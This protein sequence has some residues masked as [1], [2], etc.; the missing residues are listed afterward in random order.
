MSPA[1]FE[2][3]SKAGLAGGGLTGAELAGLVELAGPELAGHS[4]FIFSL[5]SIALNVTKNSQLF[6]VMYSFEYEWTLWW[7]FKA[8][9]KQRMKVG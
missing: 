5:N 7:Y 6:K 9:C 8:V 1:G 4:C 3:L 2:G